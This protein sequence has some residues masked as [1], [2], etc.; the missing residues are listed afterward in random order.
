MCEIRENQQNIRIH[1]VSCLVIL[2]ETRKPWKRR[3][4]PVGNKDTTSLVPVMLVEPPNLGAKSP[5]WV[6]ADYET[7]K[8]QVG[9]LAIYRE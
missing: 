3:N 5:S 1:I 6:D 8:E 7:M 2:A 4:T 9:N